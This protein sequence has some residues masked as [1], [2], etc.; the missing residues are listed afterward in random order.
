MASVWKII[1]ERHECKNLLTRR[2]WLCFPFPWKFYGPISWNT[3]TTEILQA[4]N[5]E[6]SF[7][8]LT[9]EFGHRETADLTR[10]TAGK[11]SPVLGSPSITWQD[12]TFSIEWQ[13]CRLESKNFGNRS[14]DFVNLGVPIYSP[15]K[16]QIP[17]W[18]PNGRTDIRIGRFALQPPN[19]A[20]TW[21]REASR[22]YLLIFGPV[23]RKTYNN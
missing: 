3:K 23:R 9:K 18:W 12:P 13:T 11:S 5:L 22:S 4:V 14:L 20:W 1:W 21:R 17:Y 6:G 16:R 7:S 10:C 8:L 2:I 19:R 15:V